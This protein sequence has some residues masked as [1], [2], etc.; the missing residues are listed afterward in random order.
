MTVSTINNRVIMECEA[1]NNTIA[2]EHEGAVYVDSLK[3][4]RPFI[5]LAHEYGYRFEVLHREHD[6]LTQLGERSHGKEFGGR[7]CICHVFRLTK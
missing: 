2:W 7:K 1:Y 6:E 4:S 5:A 3:G